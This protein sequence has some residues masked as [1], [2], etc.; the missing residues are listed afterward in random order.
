MMKLFKMIKSFFLSIWK[1]IDKLIVF[2]ITKLVFKI[3]SKLTKSNKSIVFL[4][5]VVRREEDWQ[6][7]LSD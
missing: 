2:P 4:F 5:E 1:V 6:K 3:T 7:K